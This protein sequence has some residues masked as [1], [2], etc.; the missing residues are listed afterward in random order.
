MNVILV[1]DEF[2]ARQN[3]LAIFE[4]LNVDIN[5]LAC[6]ESIEDAVCWIESNPKPEIAFFD[7]QLADGVSFEIFDKTEVSFPVVFTTAF[8]EYAIKAFKVNSIDY[9]LKPIKKSDIEFAIN[10]YQNSQKQTITD[11]KLLDVLHTI[12]NKADSEKKTILIKKYDG[13]VPVPVSDFAFFFIENGIVY[14][15]THNEEKHVVDETLDV[16]EDKLNQTDFFRAN[17]QFIASRKTIIEVNNYFNGRLMLKT[18][19]KI[20]EQIMISKVRVN[21]FRGWLEI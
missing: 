16:L 21:I 14:G 3:M 1:E 17:R 9:I 2:S 8:D 10:K 11:K 5:V 15:L 13:F 18:R 6:L 20:K 4:E 12:T 7:I 19:P